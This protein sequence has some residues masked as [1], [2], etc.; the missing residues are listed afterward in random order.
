MDLYQ[1]D[2]PPPRDWQQLQRISKDFYQEKY[3]NCA[4][5]EY[6]KH[7]QEQH[8]VDTY[9]YSDAEQIGIQCKRVEKF[10]SANLKE[11]VEKTATFPKQLRR[12]IVIVT[13]DRDTEL[14]N[15]A[16]SL[17]RE[18][19]FLIEVKFWPSLAEEVASSEVL[20]GKHFKFAVRYE[21]MVDADPSSALVELSG[22]GNYYRFVVTKMASFDKFKDDNDLL[23]VSSLQAGKSAGF[24]RLN[25][26]YWTDFEQ[27]IGA[28]AF[29]AY[30][31][32]CWFSQF[33]SFESIRKTSRNPQGVSI[34]EQERKDFFEQFRDSDDN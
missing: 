5:D 15:V 2:I 17:T 28:G 14:Q 1:A 34:S 8:G 24:H 9:I 29:D 22:H 25:G 26:G 6:G 13:I 3:P 12:Y 33:D 20:A 27:V 19:G 7:G 10:S 4:V 11:E 23:L 18:K 32:W 16:A 30:L 31:V 21:V